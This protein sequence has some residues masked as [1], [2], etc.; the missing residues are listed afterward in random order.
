MSY[1]RNDVEDNS[2]GEQRMENSFG[3]K[4]QSTAV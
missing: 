2:V 3:E 1:E 4:S